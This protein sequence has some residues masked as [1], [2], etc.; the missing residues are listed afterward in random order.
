MLYY[1]GSVQKLCKTLGGWEE[2]RS[3]CYVEMLAAQNY[4]LGPMFALL[5]VCVCGGVRV[6]ACVCVCVRVGT[7]WG[8]VGG[9]NL[10]LFALHNLLA[11]P[12]AL[13][14]KRATQRAESEEGQ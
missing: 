5:D 13:S 6:R 2:A 8:G 11:L 3:Q 12:T 1:Y 9:K 10:H 7:R 14:K 4:A